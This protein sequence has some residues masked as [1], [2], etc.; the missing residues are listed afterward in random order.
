MSAENKMSTVAMYDCDSWNSNQSFVG[1]FTNRYKLEKA[2][3][4]KMEE[5]DI[6]L[7]DDSPLDLPLKN[8]S[9]DDIN[10]YFDYVTLERIELNELI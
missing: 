2:L 8:F 1:V 3:R 4:K 9:I 5:G 7:N 6:V 10:L